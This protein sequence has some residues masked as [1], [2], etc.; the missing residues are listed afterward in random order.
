MTGILS[1]WNDCAPE[2]LEHFER[3]YNGEHLME[4][5]GVP[6][7][8]FGRRYE[9][10]SGGDRRFMAFYEVDSPAVLTSR[11]YVERLEN[12]GRLLEVH[13]DRGHVVLNNRV[14][15]RRGRVGMRSSKC[16]N[17]MLL[18]TSIGPAPGIMGKRLL[19]GKVAPD[20]GSMR[21]DM[22]ANRRGLSLCCEHQARNKHGQRGC[23]LP[24]RG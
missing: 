13:A 18:K 20:R 23:D 10:V 7:F 16:R 8:R 3:W 1:V 6:G 2:G 9:L 21:P 14:V 17:G 15:V 24:D 4:R 5:V 19:R 11:P 22:F 12:R